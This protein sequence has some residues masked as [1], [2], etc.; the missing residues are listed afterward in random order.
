MSN[1]DSLLRERDEL[2]ARLDAIHR[3]YRSGLSAD[4]SEQAIELENADT[5]AEIERVTAQRLADVLQQL[6]AD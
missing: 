1:R 3:D 6:A 5:L 2:Q 4:A